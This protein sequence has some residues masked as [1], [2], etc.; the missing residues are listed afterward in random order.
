M[1]REAIQYIT[2][3]MVEDPSRTVLFVGTKES[4]HSPFALTKSEIVTEAT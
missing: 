4:V 1:F 3:L 2:K